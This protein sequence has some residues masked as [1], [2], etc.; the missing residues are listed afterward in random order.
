M[1]MAALGK[2]VYLDEFSKLLKFDPPYNFELNQKY[3]H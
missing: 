3:L 2:P 1:G